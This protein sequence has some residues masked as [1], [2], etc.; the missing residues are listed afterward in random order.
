MTVEA[1][2]R[3]VCKAKFVEATY[4]SLRDV[5]KSMKYFP[6][7]W[8]LTNNV[9]ITSMAF[10]AFQKASSANDIY[11]TEAWEQV[12]KIKLL[13]TA[14]GDISSII[15][16]FAEFMADPPKCLGNPKNASTN[17]D[18]KPMRDCTNPADNYV[19]AIPLRKLK[20]I[21]EKL[22]NTLKLLNGVIKFEKDVYNKRYS[23]DSSGKNKVK[24][25]SLTD[26][27]AQ[28]MTTN[29]NSQQGTVKCSD[30]GVVWNPRMDW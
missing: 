29:T 18:T 10:D 5:Q 16:L 30:K 21:S 27:V 2:N 6:K 13:L 24:V 14:R 8:N 20:I 9:F 25:V 12:Y 7:H 4:E 17:K 22:N 1:T 3:T 15:H 23:V 26:A 28:V 19:V 11:A